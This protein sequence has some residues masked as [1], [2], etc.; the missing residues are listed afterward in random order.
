[1]TTLLNVITPERQKLKRT[2]NPRVMNA[3]AV[4]QLGLPFLK[5]TLPLGIRVTEHVM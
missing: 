3:I 2:P 5:A 1:M 4:F